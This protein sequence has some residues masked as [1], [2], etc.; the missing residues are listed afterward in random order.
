VLLLLKLQKP[1]EGLTKETRISTWE[2]G[3]TIADRLFETAQG[4]YLG[5][6]DLSGTISWLKDCAR[7]GGALSLEETGGI[8]RI[9]EDNM[10]KVLTNRDWPLE[11]V[12]VVS[13]LTDTGDSLL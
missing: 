12:G 10:A 11:W 2:S 7:G 3:L 1:I 5:L 13:E 9:Q 8:G 4:E 6:P